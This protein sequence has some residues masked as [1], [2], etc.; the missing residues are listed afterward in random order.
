MKEAAMTDILEFR[1]PVCGFVGLHE[2]PRSKSGGGSYEFCPSC[3]FEF[4]VTDGDLG[5][6]DEDWRSKWV[7]EGMQWRSKSRQKPSGWNPRE[8]LRG[9]LESG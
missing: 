4:G 5:F 2:P 8:Q 1:C 3:D 9:L 7:E 6:S